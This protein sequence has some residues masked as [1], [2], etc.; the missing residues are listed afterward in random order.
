MTLTL[1]N[2]ALHI[3]YPSA[4][5]HVDAPLDGS[6]AAV[7]GPH[8]P[9]GTTLAVRPAGRREFRTVTKRQGKL[10]SQGTL[11]LSNDGRVITDSWWNPSQPTDKGTLAYNKQ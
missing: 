9:E 8:V 5:Q 11:E 2:Q 3:D 6:D 4:G 10:F 1:D 7:R